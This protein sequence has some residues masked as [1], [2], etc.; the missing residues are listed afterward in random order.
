MPEESGTPFLNLKGWNAVWLFLA[1]I[2]LMAFILFIDLQTPLGVAIDVLYVL[3]VSLSFWS[4]STR[5]TIL[6]A[7]ASSVL[8][9]GAF[10]FQ[11]S[12]EEM[13]KAAFN[14]LIALFTIWVTALLIVM[15]KMAEEKRSQA[16]LERQ[17]ALEDVKILRG[18][19]PI[20]ASCKKI[21][22][23]KGYWE[24]LE[25]YITE[26]SEALFSHGICPECAKRLYPEL[27]KKREMADKK[28]VEEPPK[29]TGDTTA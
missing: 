7:V 22:N 15:R 14:R 5:I 20:C 16:M 4:P 3:V 24:Q 1:C 29:K 18:F 17:K 12:V 2:P 8:T 23:D 27:H 25:A 28:H 9:V 26:H 21:R 11:P 13:W 10:F 6:I 19:L